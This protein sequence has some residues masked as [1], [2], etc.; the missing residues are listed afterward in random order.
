MFDSP[1]KTPKSPS[2]VSPDRESVKALEELKIYDQPLDSKE[3]N[4]RTIRP[5]KVEMFD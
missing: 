1:I 4:M 2:Q 5:K 3:Q